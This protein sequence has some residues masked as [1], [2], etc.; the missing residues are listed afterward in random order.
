[1]MKTLDEV[2][3]N[4]LAGEFDL[5]DHAFVRA[6]ER[7]I[8]DTEVMEAG[9][10]VFLVEDYEDARYGPSAL[11][12]GFTL[13]GRPLHILVSLSDTPLLRIITLYEPDPNQWE[14]Y[15]YRR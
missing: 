7:N 9:N 3:E 6:V 1:M 11:V 13:A 12:L 14:D 2:R 5:S 10:S 8:S 15:V 4:L